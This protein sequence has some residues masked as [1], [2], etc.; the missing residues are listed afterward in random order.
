MMNTALA[1]G[2]IPALLHDGFVVHADLL[3]PAELAELRA[4]VDEAVAA[5]GNRRIAGG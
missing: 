2:P 4:A 5:L 3:T 1:P